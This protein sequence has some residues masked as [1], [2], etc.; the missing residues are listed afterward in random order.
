M[1]KKYLCILLC[2]IVTTFTY[3]NNNIWTI[4]GVVLS[5]DDNE[6]LIGATVSVSADDLKNIN[7]K[8]ISI[9][10]ITDI[11][12]K[13]SIS[14][15]RGITR[16]LCSYIGYTEH[17]VT[18]KPN[19]KN[20]K[21][22]LASSAQ[23]LGDVVVTGYQT[24]EKRKLTASI[25]KVEMSEAMVGSKT[26]IDQALTGQIAGVAVT[27]TSGAP[28][29]PAKIRIRGTASLNGTQDP[30]WVLDGIP[31]EGTDIPKMSDSNDNDITNIGQSSIAG[32]SPSDIESITILKDAAATAIYGARAANGVIVVTSKRGKTG[33]PS[34]NFS[35]KFTYTPN[36][37]TDRLNLLNSEE[38]VNLELELLSAP[39]HWMFGDPY[40]SK[41]GVANILRNNNELTKYKNFGWSGISLD[42]QN[43]INA[44]KEI[45]TNWNDILFSD[46]FTQEY[47]L[48]ISGGSDK[49]TYYN[50]LGYTNENGNIPGVNMERFNL[51]SKT[52]YQVNKLLKFGVSLF[53]NRRKNNSFVT[54]TYGY[55][56]PVYY[57]RVANSYYSPYDS[58]NNYVYDYDIY[59]GSTPDLTRGFNIF[60]EREN[61]SNETVTTSLNSIF[62]ADLRFNDNWKISSQLGVQLDDSKQEQYVGQNTFNMRHMREN[63]KY[64]DRTSKM[65]KYVLPE[66]GMHKVANSKTSQVTWKTQGEYKNTFANIHDVQIMVGSEIRKNWY[67]SESSTGYGYDPRTLTT[68][69]LI[70]RDED[71]AK[72]YP[73]SSSGYTVN[74]F[75]S[76]FANGSYSLMDKYTVGGSIRLDGSDMFGV[77]KKYRYLPIYSVSGLWRASNENFM[78]DLTW[79]DNLALRLSYGIQGN[80]DKNTS[81]FLV[82][83]YGNVSLLPNSNES[84]IDISSAPNS[85]LRWE[86]T[87]SYNVGLDF[88]I[89]NQ[90]INFNVDYYYRKGTDLIGTKALPLEN[91]FTSMSI[92]WASMENKGI[93]VNMRTRNIATKDFSWYTTFNFAYNQNKVLKN[94]TPE[95]Q[96]TPGLEGYAVGA[97]FALKSKVDPETGRI[98]VADNNGKF[99]TLENLYKMADETGLGFYS[100]GLTPSEERGLYYYTGTSDAPYSGGFINTFNYK[101]WE[102]NLNFSYNIGAKVRTSPS[103][104][105]T[106]FDTGRNTNRDILDR[107][108]SENKTGKFP[109]LLTPNDYGAD[110]SLLNGRSDIYRSLDLWVKD[111]SYVRLQNIR[112]A[113]N[114][115]STLLNRISVKNATVGIEA[116]NLFVLGTSYK[117]YMDPESMGNLYSTPVAKSFTF[118]LN[119]NF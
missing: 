117:N 19:Q 20:Y 32:L 79:I 104:S 18:I 28:G 114:I 24:L 54:D 43:A 60:E 64:M 103:Y 116:R 89:L 73:L 25:A 50:S 11:E 82:G 109:T 13:F 59:T 31:L 102:L 85:K 77:D 5:A 75:A 53:A 33:K 65:F 100:T 76:F 86:K 98:L 15:P 99:Q 88:G 115:P 97:I 66:G 52:S 90:A 62:N 58:N 17:Y 30:L 72:S 93:E 39:E 94:M 1:T 16:I 55:S 69:P 107:W 44:L 21:I 71:Q 67:E 84:N 46:A 27:N 61:T 68:K 6:P 37:D 113:Y 118:N 96:T 49:V 48:S 14:I 4:T 111:L 34:I 105:V 3:A 23:N 78:K 106:G 83:Y 9:G 10:T 70:F 47:N 81:P 7:S 38:K 26:S 42:S 57:S 92:N 112:L 110:Y 108:T 101:N 35:S 51:T 40:P 95:N 119:I 74:A 87:T 56:N 29:A 41:G 63:S 22:I 8:Q 36:L 80:I 12:G 45:N 91:G 2:L